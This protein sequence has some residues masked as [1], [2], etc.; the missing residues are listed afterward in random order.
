M[1]SWMSAMCKQTPFLVPYNHIRLSF[2]FTFTFTSSVEINEDLEVT[3]TIYEGTVDDSG[4]YTIRAKNDY[5]E[6]SDSLQ[7][8]VIYEPPTFD[9]PLS[10]LTILIGENTTFKCTFHGK[11]EPQTKW[12]ISGN[13]VYECD[14][15]HIVTE[16]NTTS[17]EVVNVTREDVEQDYTCKIFSPVGEE[18][19]TAKLV[20]QGLFALLFSS[21]YH[22]LFIAC[23]LRLMCFLLLYSRCC[24][25]LLQMTPMT[26]LTPLT[27]TLK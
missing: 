19:S 14:K 6:I 20:P 21:Y 13:E 7:V 3:L 25:S 1:S 27:L 26:C 23:S 11:P 5:G 9:Q 16:R 10:D 12:I 17:L 22:S 15:Y 8:T 2:I 18:V 4:E 24:A